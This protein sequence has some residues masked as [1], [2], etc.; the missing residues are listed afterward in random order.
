MNESR[1]RE[2]ICAIGQSLFNRGYTHG[3]AGNISLRIDDGWLITATDACLGRLD[4]AEIAKMATTGHLAEGVRPSKSL[5]LHRAIYGQDSRLRAI[6]HTHSTSLVALSLLGV[7][8]PLCVV[9]PLT[10]YFVMKVGQIPLIRYHRPGSPQV[11]KLVV[12]HVHSARGVLLERLGP[13]VWHSTLDEAAHALEELEQSARLH[14]V[15]ANKGIAP[16]DEGQI[17]DL[18]AAFNLSWQAEISVA[19]D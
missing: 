8:H 16:L 18:A 15:L 3:T 1:A 10:P 19:A 7:W 17:R 6:V 4:P 11:I 13:V 14:L 9:A 5:A 12:P 2:K